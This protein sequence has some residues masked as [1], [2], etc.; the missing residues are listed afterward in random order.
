M[1]MQSLLL[2]LAIG[3]PNCFDIGFATG[4]DAEIETW[5][6]RA[7]VNWFVDDVLDNL[8]VDTF[9]VV[10]ISIWFAIGVAIGFD[11]GCVELTT[12]WRRRAF[13][14]QLSIF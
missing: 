5:R 11:I 7:L 2:V 14:N 10:W 3:V 13:V 9:V 4:N 8:D 12:L 1:S 6:R